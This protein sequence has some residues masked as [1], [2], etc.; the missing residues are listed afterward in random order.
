MRLIF[1]L[2]PVAALAVV[3]AACGSSSSAAGLQSGDVAVVDNVH[4]TKAQLDHQI[5]LTLNGYKVQHTKPP[6]AGSSTYK[7]QVLDRSLQGLVFAAKVKLIAQQL[8]ISVSPAAVQKK[9]NAAIQQSYQGDRSK[10]LAAL[11]TYGATQQDVFNQFQESLLGEAIQHKIQSEV[12]ADTA[13]AQA[14]YNQHK[15]L[16]TLSADTRKVNYILVPDKA[17]AESD[18]AKLR[19]GQSQAT[20]ANGA[21][22]SNTAHPPVQP[23]AATNT[24]G[25]L[26]ANFQKAA[27]NQVTGQWGQPVKVSAKYASTQLKGRCKPDCYFLIEPVEATQP[28]GTVQSFASVKN[29]IIQQLK[30]TTQTSHFQQRF[31]ALLNALDKQTKYAAGFAPPAASTSPATTSSSSTATS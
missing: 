13:A 30:T 22:D 6:A 2:L 7:T 12:P 15:T 20:V 21:I 11:K 31:T 28:K 16:Y 29:Q 26:E 9:I 14:Y 4:I 17:T 18:L 24:P 3:L 25:A 8:G 27:F 5:R 19:A 1:R 23:L 10:Y